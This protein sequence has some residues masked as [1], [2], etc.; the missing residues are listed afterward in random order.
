MRILFQGDSIT[1]A[2]RLGTDDGLGMGYPKYAAGLITESHPGTQFEF[3]NRGT[4]GDRICDLAGRW[5]EDCIDLKPDI[6]SVLIGINDCLK[7]FLNPKSYLPDEE[8]EKMYRG[9]LELTKEKTGAKIIMLEPFTVDHNT[10]N[11]SFYDD[12]FRKIRITRHLAREYADAFV[13]LDGIFA[14]AV[15][16]PGTWP[17]IWSGDSVH[18]FETGHRLIAKHYAEAFEKIYSKM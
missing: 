6:V 13:A 17:D 1:D 2:G 11:Q 18:P 4:G 16:G 9:I 15:T 8:F 10:F 12:L 7:Y 5:Q 14:E 3:I